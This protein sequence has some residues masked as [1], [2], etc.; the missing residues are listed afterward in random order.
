MKNKGTLLTYFD[1]TVTELKTSNPN[2]LS[3]FIEGAEGLI[4]EHNNTEID[5]RKKLALGD[6]HFV[7]E[8]KQKLLLE[9]QK[10][11]HKTIGIP[12]LNS[13]IYLKCKIKVDREASLEEL[14]KRGKYAYYGTN[15][16]T[17]NYPKPDWEADELELLIIEFGEFSK[18]W[19]EKMVEKI[20][21]KYGHLGRFATVYDL[22]HLGWQHPHIQ[23][24]FIE[25]YGFGSHVKTREHTYATSEP[26]W[27][28]PILTYA[29]EDADPKVRGFYSKLSPVMWYDHKFCS[30]GFVIVK[31]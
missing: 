30:T 21:E 27:K 18:L 10:T 12:D 7:P 1:D 20:T 31:K 6:F 14:V 29:Y 26:L 8:L 15:L 25:L 13:D 5:V 2:A 23:E 24:R 28:A 3:A 22:A 4:S 19:Y 16:T 11:K 17:E 9:L